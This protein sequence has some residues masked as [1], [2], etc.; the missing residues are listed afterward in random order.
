LNK[1]KKV[2]T[3]K[4]SH[5]H[6]SNEKSHDNIPPSKI[7]NLTITGPNENDLGDIPDK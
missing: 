5:M 7:T 3:N 2:L 6:R 1:E 4:V